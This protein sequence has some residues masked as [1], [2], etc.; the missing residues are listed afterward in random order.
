MDV[1]FCILHCVVLQGP[2]ATFTKPPILIDLER[3]EPSVS[4][5]TPFSKRDVLKW[6]RQGIYKT[7]PKKKEWII[8]ENINI[9]A[10]A[11]LSIFPEKKKKPLMPEVQ[12]QESSTSEVK[13]VRKRRAPL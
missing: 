2:Q 11:L 1:W 5:S 8:G 3:Y 4:L 12:H 7:R 6:M 13:R 9:N 10:K